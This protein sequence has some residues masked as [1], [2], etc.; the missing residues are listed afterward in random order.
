MSPVAPG[1]VPDRASL[2]AT[3][4]VRFAEWLVAHGRAD[5]GDVTD[6]AELH[7]WSAGHPGEFWGAVADFFEVE[8]S[9]QP[10]VALAERRMPGAVWFPGGSLNFGQHLLRHGADDHEAVVLVTESG[11]RSSLTFGR[12]RA[13]AAAVAGRLRELGVGPGDRVVGYLPNCLEGVVAFTAV[14]LVG[15][16][17]AQAG[18]DYASTAAADRLGQ[19]TPKV[20]IAGS[21][22]RFGGRVHDR[23]GEVAELRALL[24]GLEHTI[25]VATGGVSSPVPDA[26]SSSWAGALAAAPDG[27]AEPVPFEHPLWVLFT[28][29]TTGKPKGIV[30]GHGGVLLEQLVSPGLHM[31][32]HEGDVFFWFTTPNWMMWNAQVCGLLH[33]ATI[34][35]FDGRPTS[36]GPDALWRVV[37]DLGVTVFGTSPAYL[38]ASERAGL[39]P[40]RDL[41]LSAVRL[42]GATGS[43]L[44]AAAN[45]WVREHVG[46]RVQL[47][48]MSGGTDVVGIFVG[49]APTTPVVDGEICAVALGVSLQ[50]WDAA[51]EQ[52]APGEPGE[53]VITEPMPSMPLRF[54]DDPDG[55]RLRET[56]FST[57]PGFWRQGDLMLLTDRGTAVILGRSDATINRSGVRLGSAEIYE[58]IGGMPDVEDA[59]AVGVEQRDGG[60]WFP[61]FVVAREDAEPGDLTRRIRERIRARTSPRHVPDDVILLRRLPHTKTGKRLEVPVKRIL[62]GAD[63]DTVL[64]RGAVDDPEALDAIVTFARSRGRGT[65]T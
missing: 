56:Y 10:K 15:A 33:G 13:Q 25:T 52:V 64:N 45:A 3:R 12:L 2:Q 6:Y 49:S 34:V 20:L 4:V 65:E 55:S 58:A 42:I 18:L 11:E 7:A 38:E 50:V 9:D 27:R 31:D 29:G 22:Y 47:G 39:E 37:A 59:L 61:L 36:P 35:L 30:H 48:S 60:Y 16:V 1:W 8:W 57:F 23:R 21:G 44:P 62:Q 63:P 19:L 14:A 28:S 43:V 40:G 46:E 54:W 26:G 32:L 24:P 51:G 5:L 53:M 41:D 17:W